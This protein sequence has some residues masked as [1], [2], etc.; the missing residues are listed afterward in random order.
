MFGFKAFATAALGETQDIQVVAISVVTVPRLQ[1]FHLPWHLGKAQEPAEGAALVRRFAILLGFLVAG[2]GCGFALNPALDI[3]QYAH[4]SWTV[5]DGFALGNIYA[6]AQTP[7]G[8]LWFGTEFGLFR[9]D[10]IRT[11]QWQPP[12][13]QHLPDEKN[14]NSLLVT[15]DGTLWIGTFAG[16]ATWDG[17]R[18]TMRPELGRQFVS[19]LFEDREGTVW[20]ATLEAPAGRLCAIRSSG[21]QCYAENGA[22][23]RAIWALYEDESGTLWAGAQSGLWRWQ[24]GPPR[25]YASEELIALNRAGDGRLLI[26]VHGGGLKQISGDKLEPFPIS[27]P[28]HSNPPLRDP[29]VDSNRLL[30]DRDGGLWIGTVER[31][32]I[33]IHNGRTDI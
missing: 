33:H 9:F 26:A 11:S 8:F 1:S 20:A 12:A 21:N 6:I 23:G 4:T 13:G 10:G 25:R 24:P 16:L 32:L 31:G 15:R 22:F 17:R 3:S 14:I 18:L 27:S 28:I 2:C 7:D 19:S 30:R 29:D 5:R